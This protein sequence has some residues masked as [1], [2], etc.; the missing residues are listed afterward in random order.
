MKH[1]SFIRMISAVLVVPGLIR[2]EAVSNESE[3]GER[4]ASVA[5]AAEV[6]PIEKDGWIQVAPY[7]DHEGRIPGRLQHFHKEQA[8]AMVKE[9]NSFKGRLGRMFRGRSIF[10]GHPDVDPKLWPD[11]RRLGKIM[12]VEARDDGLY[13]L[14]D[15]N[16]LG[17]S[18]VDEGYWVY[19]SP[20]WD[21]PAGKPRFEPDRL[22]SIG[23]T[24]NPRITV[25]EPVSNTNNQDKTMDRQVLIQKLGL[26]PEATDEEILA[27]IVALTEAAGSGEGQQSLKEMETSLSEANSARETAENSLNTANGRITELEDE[28]RAARTAHSNSLLDAAI[29]D[30]RIEKCER[31]SWETQFK[32]DFE[33]ASNSLKGREPRLNTQ[34]IQLEHSRQQ[35]SD[36]RG[37]REQIA[38]AVDKVMAETG[39]NY[40]EA[41][42]SVKANPEYKGLFEAMHEPGG[43]Q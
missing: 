15:W 1:H 40:R 14:P 31:E 22:I 33:A 43:E 16:S 4:R 36:E 42:A 26:D 27:K 17:S 37:R 25:S 8:Q 18:N 11:E 7:G 30:T 41:H 20:H 13:A 39:K 38:N 19:P 32:S 29:A 3:N 5:N 34:Q 2:R 12:E 9:F 10:I 21:A 24:N 28:V 35:V 6:K 23:L